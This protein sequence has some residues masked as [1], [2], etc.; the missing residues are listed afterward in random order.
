MAPDTITTGPLS[1]EDYRL[2]FRAR[3]RLQRGRLEELRSVTPSDH[4]ETLA[5]GLELTQLMWREGWK[6]HGWPEDVG[7]LGGGLRHRAVY[8][9]ELCN[10]G[11]FVPESDNG[12]ETLAP[13]LLRFAPE[14][15][16]ELLP[17][18]LSGQEAWG[19]CFSEPDAGSDLAGLRTRAVAAGDG[20]AV[21]GQ[22]TWTSN[23]HLSAR[24]FT[25]ARTGARDSRRHGISAL[26]IDSDS[27][28][29]SRRALT[30]ASGEPELCEVFFDDVRVPRSR[31][32][33]E[34]NGGWDVSSYLLQ[35]ERS[36]YAA[37][38]QAWLFSTLR[39]LAADVAALDQAD[40]C[41]AEVV[42][43]AWTAVASLRAR[44]IT[45]V[46][47]LDAGE[48]VGPE[49]SADKLLLGVA[50]QAVFDAA[51]QLLGAAFL[52]DDDSAGWR[53]KWWYS[54]A[55]TVYGGAAEVQRTI[56]ADRVLG[57]PPEV[58]RSGK[59]A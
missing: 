8:Y 51:R 47:R 43:K 32:I 36:M 20:Y 1:L 33:G 15:A 2:A 23:G 19:Q 27:P 57:L 35:F 25:L 50:E 6:R 31:L 37:Q 54:R 17:P 48:A 42:G 12:L 41:A 24:L 59:R 55:A 5:L 44:T 40:A 14:L 13:A 52:F 4:E 34:E 18:L 22:K 21:S 26:L 30:F 9:D 28:G 38:R 53:S 46:R 29:I 39:A 56:L 49:A 7:G 16:R 10:A 58:G 11:L 3:L 45:T